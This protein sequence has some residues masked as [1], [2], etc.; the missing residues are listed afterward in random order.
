MKFTVAGDMLVQRRIPEGYA[1]FYE[2]KDY[3]EKGDARFFNLLRG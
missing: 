3:I 2:V 1:G